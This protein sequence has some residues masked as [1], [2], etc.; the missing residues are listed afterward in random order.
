M[1]VMDV[2]ASM[3]KQE[4][5][6]T[7][8]CY[9]TTPIIEAAAQAGIRPVLCRQERVGVDMANGYTRIKNGRPFG[10]F[11]M[12][13]GPGAENAFSGIATAY[14]DSSP[15]LLLPLGHRR[16]VAQVAPTFRSSRAYACVTRSV[17]EVVA[18]EEIPNVMRR[19][20]NHLKNGRL[21]PVMIEFPMDLVEHELG[22]MPLAF[23]GVRQVRS[24]ADE[25]DIDAAAALLL[26]AK[27]PIIQAGQGIFYAEACAELLELA[28]LASLPVITTVE[29]KSAFPENHPLSLGTSGAVLTGH[30][31]HFLEHADLVLAVGSSLTRHH[32][33][34]RVMPVA[35]KKIIH[36]VS[37]PRDLYKGYETDVALLG[38]AKLVLRQLIEAVRDR[39]G[40]AR[41]GDPRP[42]ILSIK[43][44]WLAE[45]RHKLES[46][47]VPITPYRAIHEFMNAVPAAEAIVTHDSGSPRD[48]ILPF[49]EA[50]TPH[51]YLG[52]GKSHALGTG[53]GLTIGAKL[54]AP[55]KFCV[56]FMGDAAFGMTGLDFETAVRVGAPI[57]TVVFNN[58]T[59]A[60]ETNNMK[61]SHA[62]YGTR[63]IGGNYA[64]IGRDLGG[65]AERVDDPAQLAAAFA[66]AR[67][68][69][70]EGHPVLLEI[71]TSEERDFSFRKNSFAALRAA[72]AGAA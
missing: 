62:R 16:E 34:N 66:R 18:P 41:R 72:Q 11:A 20:I 35:E 50:T 14:S 36:A 26:E 71:M 27:C 8:F 64:G 28:E 55:D 53:L 60:V 10:V 33:T 4:G 67:R 31:N 57:C 58:A 37:D 48:Q 38:D 59:M 69:T 9:P 63:D 39:L 61:L 68:K 40:N 51:S 6:D 13:Y 17:E 22:D 3:L 70:E 44:A 42:Q 65:Y 29:G 46:R 45:W 32:L 19:A 52:W 23:R 15:I 43:Q 49:Y 5:I 21:G 24:A 47:A 54:A 25:R 7:L 30:G 2:V 56:N 1:R 12:Q